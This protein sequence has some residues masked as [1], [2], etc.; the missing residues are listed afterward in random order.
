MP[1]QLGGIWTSS[2]LPPGTDAYRVPMLVTG[3]TG[4]LGMAAYA[5]YFHRHPPPDIPALAP[6]DANRPDLGRT[7]DSD[8]S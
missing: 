5:V 8:S 2:V 1:L 4:M 6:E 7:L 3:I